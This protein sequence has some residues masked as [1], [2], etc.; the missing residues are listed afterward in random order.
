MTARTILIT[1]ILAAVLAGFVVYTFNPARKSD[2][3]SIAVLRIENN[4]NRFD[5][6]DRLTDLVIDAFKADGTFKIVSPENADAS[7]EG[8]FANYSERPYEWDEN[9]VVSSYSVSMTFTITLTKPD[10]ETEMWTES[11]TQEGI[12]QA[13]GETEEDAQTEAI[14]RLIDDIINKTTKSW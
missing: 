14:D 10:D 11:F 5:L 12:Y 9:D 1:L 2:I 3:K 13:D 6:A 8:T 7:L 4:T